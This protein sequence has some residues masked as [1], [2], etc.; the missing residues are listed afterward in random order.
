M[1]DQMRMCRVP[2]VYGE[3]WLP[4]Q[5]GKDVEEDVEETLVCSEGWGA[6][7]LQI[8]SQFK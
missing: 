1:P 5:D 7:L 6:S 4:A 3:V 2:G 8:T